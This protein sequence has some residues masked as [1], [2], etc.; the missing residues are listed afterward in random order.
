MPKDASSSPD[1]RLHHLTAKLLAAKKRGICEKIPLDQ[2]ITGFVGSLSVPLILARTPPILH[3]GRSA[4]M[5]QDIPP[6]F[7]CRELG[8]FTKAFEND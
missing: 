8:E 2:P 1:F 6:W 5:F 7:H 4:K 3:Y